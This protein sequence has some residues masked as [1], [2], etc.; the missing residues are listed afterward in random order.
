M[1]NITVSR[2]ADP[3]AL[4]EIEVLR[5]RHEDN[6]AMIG[7]LAL[8]SDIELPVEDDS[9]TEGVIGHEQ[10]GNDD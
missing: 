6:A 7:Y 10:A 8:M 1:D 3:A 2:V 5:A 4:R 9:E